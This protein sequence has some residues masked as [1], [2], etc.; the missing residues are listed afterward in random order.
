LPCD[1]TIVECRFPEQITLQ[2]IGDLAVA[3]WRRRSRVQA[4]DDARDT[5]QRRGQ[6]ERQ[7]L[8]SDVRDF[9]RQDRDI[10]VVVDFDAVP[11]A[12]DSRLASGSAGCLLLLKRS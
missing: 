7:S 5:R 11:V 4:I 2:V 1:P 12:I 8:R 3:Q 10:I 6:L 9:A